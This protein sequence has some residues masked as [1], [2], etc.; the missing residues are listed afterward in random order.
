MVVIGEKI[1]GAIPS[2]AEAIKSRDR[3]FIDTLISKQEAAGADYLDICA[4]TP[5]AEEYDALCWLIDIVQEKAALPVCI[6]SPDPIM[7][8]RVLPKLNKP[9]IINSVSLETGKCEALMPLLRENPDWCAVGLCCGDSGIARTAD[10][11]VRN[12]FTLLERAGEYGI[13]PDRIYVDPLVLALSAMDDSAL[14][15]IEAV[16]RIK[17]RYPEVHVTAAISNISYGMPARKLINAHFLVLAMEAGLDSIIA[18][19]AGA[20]IAAAIAAGSALL[21]KDRLCRSY[22]KAY[23]AGLL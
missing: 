4:G 22:Y 23:R 1:N 20:G 15:F 11:K 6:D 2:V 19:P 10:D 21:G 14:Q 17:E 16:R 8:A 9:G 7:L 18:D 13:L 3:V 12:A 5:P